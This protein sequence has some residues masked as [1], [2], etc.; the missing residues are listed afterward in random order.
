MLAFKDRN[1]Q[2]FPDEVGYKI[3]ENRFEGVPTKDGKSRQYG[4]LR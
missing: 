1:D 4:E 2:H 3:K